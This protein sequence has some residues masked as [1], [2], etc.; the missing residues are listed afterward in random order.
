M[1]KTNIKRWPNQLEKWTIS[2]WKLVPKISEN[3]SNQLGLNQ[4]MSVWRSAKIAKSELEI[5]LYQLEVLGPIRLEI[6]LNQLE[7]F[8]MSTWK[9]GQNNT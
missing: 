4:K 2:I 7:K 8:A 9:M 3:G 1:G 6:G 5:W